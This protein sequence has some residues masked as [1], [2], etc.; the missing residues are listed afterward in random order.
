MSES[1][2]YNICKNCGIR[3]KIKRPTDNFLADILEKSDE[4]ICNICDTSSSWKRVGIYKQIT[5]DK[6]E[7]RI[8]IEILNQVRK[9]GLISAKERREIDKNWR[10]NCEDREYLFKRLKEKLCV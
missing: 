5:K 8:F 9:N 1:D 10:E 6:N 2:I 4:S 3:I 7:Y